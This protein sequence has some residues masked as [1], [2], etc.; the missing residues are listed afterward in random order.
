LR[1]AVFNVLIGLAGGG[2]KIG[3]KAVRSLSVI[4]KEQISYYFNF[5]NKA[6]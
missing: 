1:V 6:V 5:F 2:E 4:I 3:F